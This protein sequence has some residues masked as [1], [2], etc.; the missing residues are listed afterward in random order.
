MVLML[1]LILVVVESIRI[2]SKFSIAGLIS[3]RVVFFVLMVS[4]Q[5]SWLTTNFIKTV[6]FSQEGQSFCP[7]DP[8]SLIRFG[9]YSSAALSGFAEGG[10]VRGLRRRRT[11]VRPGFFTSFEFT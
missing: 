4:M 2:R 9:C 7:F 8:R 1:L 5:V 6:R 3:M 11:D 10:R